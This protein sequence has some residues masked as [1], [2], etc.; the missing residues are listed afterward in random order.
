MRQRPA[1]W[2]ARPSIRP[3][4]VPVLVYETLV[5][6]NQGVPY[7]Y[8]IRDRILPAVVNRIHAHRMR[9]LDRV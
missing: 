9:S 4:S 7:L 2:A 8:V 3:P 6:T 1:A 5:L